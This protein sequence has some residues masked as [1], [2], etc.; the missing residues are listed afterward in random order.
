MLEE[1]RLDV[2][3]VRLEVVEDQLC[4][5][6]AVVV[7]NARVVAA[8]DE[9]R[10]AVVLAADRVPDRLART[11]VAHRRR[12][13]GEEHAILRV[14]VAEQRPVAL[15]A[16]VGRHVVRLRVADKRVDE[17][18]VDG[19]ESDLGQV[20]VRA[21]DGIA[22][23]EADHATPA[24]FR[25]LRPRVGRVV[26]DLGIR[27]RYALEDR[28]T[29]AE[30]ERLLVVEPRDARVLGVGR[31]ET[32]L[33]LA[34]GV[35]L[36]DFLDLERRE[37]ATRRV[38]KSDGV[39]LWS[40]VHGQADGQRPGQAGRQAHAADDS[41]VV[42][43]T[44][45]A[46]ERRQ[47]ARRQHVEVGHFARGEGQQ[48]QRVGAFGPL[49][50]A[51]DERPAVRADELLDGDGAHEA[52]AACT[53]PSSSS[54]ATTSC[55]DSSGECASVSITSSALAGSSYGSSTPVK[56]LISPANAFS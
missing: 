3:L 46:L 17:Q 48:F 55:A 38:G 30:I 52:T 25:E 43:A 8:D 4:V 54:L 39:S 36:E 2:E 50:R 9:V 1:H 21:V 27:W 16:H 28:D 56:P 41:L 6:R 33:G 14:V 35:V 42:L 31:A 11:G 15:D 45:E 12:E 51:V 44:H 32:L 13:G 26:G 5:V 29:T 20:L 47:G 37:Q 22:G 19:F 18:A 34:L 24:A 23:L 49:A 7:A 10:A 40:L 53:S